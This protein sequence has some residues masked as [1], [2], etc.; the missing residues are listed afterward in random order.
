MSVLGTVE[1]GVMTKIVP[2]EENG[3]VIR[4]RV[5]SQEVL[6]D[7]DKD[8]G[9]NEYITA[10]N[11]KVYRK[12][13]VRTQRGLRVVD[14]S[15][16]G[17][18]NTALLPIELVFEYL[19]PLLQD[20]ISEGQVFRLE[21]RGDTTRIL[22]QGDP[23]ELQENVPS[24]FIEFFDTDMLLENDRIWRLAPA[25]QATNSSSIPSPAEDE[26]TGTSKPTKTSGH[27]KRPRGNPKAAQMAVV[28]TDYIRN[29][30]YDDHVPCRFDDTTPSEDIL[31]CRPL[32]AMSEAYR[33]K[34]EAEAAFLKSSEKPEGWD[35]KR[36]KEADVCR[37][38]LQRTSLREIVAA[39]GIWTRG[40][41]KP[42]MPVS[43]RVRCLWR[44]AVTKDVLK[45]RV[46]IYWGRPL[47]GSGEVAVRKVFKDPEDGHYNL[48]VKSSPS[49][50]YG[51]LKKL[52][53]GTGSVYKNMNAAEYI[54]KC[55][56]EENE[57]VLD[58]FVAFAKKP[59]ADDLTL[60]AAKSRI[61][62]EQRVIKGLMTDDVLMGQLG[63]ETFVDR[64]SSHLSTI[65]Q[66]IVDYNQA[67]DDI[68][69]T[70]LISSEEF[71][72]DLNKIGEGLRVRH[73]REIAY[74]HIVDLMDK[75][76]V[77]TLC[78]ENG[79]PI[80]WQRRIDTNRS[81]GISHLIEY[82]GTREIRG[83]DR[84]INGRLYRNIKNFKNQVLSPKLKNMFPTKA[85]LFEK[86]GYLPKLPSQR[87]HFIRD[88]DY[89]WSSDTGRFVLFPIELQREMAKP[90]FKWDNVA[91][92]RLKLH[93]RDSSESERSAMD[94]F[95]RAVFRT[96]FGIDDT[97]TQSVE[98]DD[99]N[100]EGQI[101]GKKTVEL[102]LFRSFEFHVSGFPHVVAAIESM[103]QI[104][105][106]ELDKG[107]VEDAASPPA[108]PLKIPFGNTEEYR[109][110]H[111]IP[112]LTEIILYFEG[113]WGGRIFAH[114][115]LNDDR[116]PSLLQI[117][118]LVPQ[119]ILDHNT[120]KDL[121]NLPVPT[122]RDCIVDQDAL[123]NLIKPCANTDDA[124][125]SLD[126][127]IEHSAPFESRNSDEDELVPIDSGQQAPDDIFLQ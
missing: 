1:G 29:P 60:L 46:R 27:K 2:I 93:L 115:I 25:A 79:M 111:R 17:F 116:T 96:V 21:K 101:I 39:E 13:K 33:A 72:Q 114:D 107:D 22:S 7:Y 52:A 95:V 30:M 91:E 118:R 100:E 106:G 44:L 70:K 66:N 67:N 108:V 83:V 86:C 47:V 90:N 98:I 8:E 15:P 81:N 78:L 58:A 26:P 87:S 97:E 121:C 105:N 109:H 16:N 127:T 35:E 41:Y 10:A 92:G 42:S 77:K 69:V 113:N 11:S 80:H 73:V 43:D 45:G 88:P 23:I 49:E 6:Y 40:Q 9:G 34:C 57:G 112:Q 120:S 82:S 50:F 55:K 102:E 38:S 63:P 24:E 89:M 19:R 64:N 37:R 12:F 3:S 85:R 28:V 61:D 51:E 110:G 32:L 76:N 65:V 48:L 56:K 124:L 117:R 123:A 84:V 68:D 99:F 36:R 53:D 14:E 31:A 104:Y 5:F 54:E 62:H 119:P 75:E 71:Q 18:N 74:K 126:V 125:C 94:Q 20:E 103:R 59:M 4:V 122:D